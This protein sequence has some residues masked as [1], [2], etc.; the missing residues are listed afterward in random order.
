MKEYNKYIN[1]VL[2]GKIVTSRFIR[3]AV[4]RLE[5]FKVREDMYFDKKAVQECFDFISCMKEWQG[6]AAGKSASL[7]PFQKW[8]VGSIIGIKWKDTDTRVCKDCFML[9]ARKNAKTSLIAKLCAYLLIC[10]GEAAP[11][12]GC[13]ASSRDQ[14]RILFEAAQ[15]YLKTIDPKCETVK[16]YRNY[17]KFPAN[18]GEF[19][20]FS[21][22]A[23]DKDGYSFSVAIC[24]ETHSY[25]DNSIISVLRS[26][27]GARKS[28]LLFQISTAGFLLEGYPCFETYKVSIEVLSGVKDDDTFF[29]FLYVFDAPE[30]IEDE[31]NWIKCNP[32]IDIIV[33]KKYLREQYNLAKNDT[34][35][36][37]PVYTKNFNLWMNSRTA[38]IPT[39][40]IAKVM[41]KFELEDFAGNTCYIG[42]DLASVGDMTSMAVFIPYDGKFYLKT[43]SFVPRETFNTSPNHELYQRF[44]EDGDLIISEGNVTDYQLIT[45]KITEIGNYLNVEGIYYDPYNSSQLAIQLTELG[46]NMQ[47]CGQGLLAF[48][49]PTKEFERMVLE[50]S[51]VIYKSIL[52]AWS[53]QCCILRVDHNSNVKCDKATPNNKIDPVIS[54]CMAIKG[55]LGNPIGSDFEIFV[56]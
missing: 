49:A 34:T 33:S 9:V 42:L 38:W 55:Y 39:E 17:I 53:V 41:K 24:D 3:Q 12:I 14:A 29:P 27:Q 22:D 25:K 7:L 30:D 40:K 2:S 19:H 13:V 16:M 23:G 44:Y 20:V 21:S 5:R 32:A 37:V 52:F 36:R 1:D 51:I 48:T 28:P 4:E 45:N 18:D 54:S 43:F 50:E 56:L 35:Q 26:S 31:N 15:K 47:P 6:A 10:D 11:F 8:I 46:F